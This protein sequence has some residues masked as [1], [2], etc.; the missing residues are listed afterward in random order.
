MNS[1]SQVGSLPFIVL[2]VLFTHTLDV[3]VT[4][5]VGNRPGE[6]VAT[7]TVSNREDM[8]E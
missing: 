7:V 6:D 5:G 1:H 3:L 4:P 2:K 8:H